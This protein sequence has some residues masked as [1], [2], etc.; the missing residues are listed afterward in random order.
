[1]KKEQ[2]IERLKK[3]NESSKRK[4]NEDKKKIDVDNIATTTTRNSP[5]NHHQQSNQNVTQTVNSDNMKIIGITGT[6]GK[7]SVAYMVH[8]YL[9]LIGKKSVLYSTVKIDSPISYNAADEPVENPLRDEKMLL[10]ILEEAVEYEAEYLIMEVNERAIKKGYTKDIPF[11]IRVITNI[12]PKHNYFYDDYLEIKKSFF[13]EFNDSNVTC[14]FGADEKELFD[15]L[16]NINNNKKVTYMS[17]YVANVKGIELSKVDYKMT[18]ST[19]HLDSIDGLSFCCLH[20]NIEEVVT[21]NLPFFYNALNIMC[22]ISILGTLNVLDYQTFKEYI[23]DIK[24]P[25]RD[26]V[27]KASGRTIIISPSVSPQLELLKKYQERE[28]IKGIKVICGTSGL[29]L[30]NRRTDFSEEKYI[31]EKEVSVNFAFNYIKRYASKV[32]VTVAD[33]AATNKEELLNYQAGFL[34]NVEHRTFIDRKEAILTAITES[35]EGDVIY[36]S[37]RGNR[38]VMCDTYD[39][40]KLILDKEVVLEVLRRLKWGA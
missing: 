38:R 17:N 11:D 28:E 24:I 21:T 19:G 5:F 36:I 31:E 40:I 20:N 32:Y 12:N 37:G 6:K 22:V 27:I 23:S 33:S 18:G 15:S 4:V 35:N 29:G 9:K 3:T 34:G 39:S 7:S 30:K 14:I 10:D 13:T 16:Y 2:L 26:E 1:M 25:G 8:E